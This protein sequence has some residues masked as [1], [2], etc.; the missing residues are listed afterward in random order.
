MDRR[1]TGETLGR[2]DSSMHT[3]WFRSPARIQKPLRR[4]RGR[5]GPH[6]GGIGRSMQ[7]AKPESP[8]LS[9]IGYHP[10]E[11]A[12]ALRQDVAMGQGTRST[13]ISLIGKWNGDGGVSRYGAN[14]PRV[15]ERESARR[16][17]KASARPAVVAPPDASASSKEDVESAGDRP[18]NPGKSG[19]VTHLG[20]AA[21]KSA[22]PAK[23]TGD[24]RRT[25]RVGAISR[26]QT[27]GVNGNGKG[28]SDEKFTEKEK[29]VVLERTFD[30][31]R[32]TIRIT[33]S[34]EGGIAAVQM[35]EGHE[36]HESRSSTGMRKETLGEFG[37]VTE[38]KG[39][40]TGSAPSQRGRLVQPPVSVGQGLKGSIVLSE[41][42]HA[43]APESVTKTNG[44]H[45]GGTVK[46]QHDNSL[47]DRKTEEKGKVISGEK[48]ANSVL[49][50][51][52][53]KIRLDH[54]QSQSL[55]RPNS[56]KRLKHAGPTSPQR[57]N[58]TQMLSVSQTPGQ[59]SLPMRSGQTAK[60]PS[61]SRV[62]DTCVSEKEAL[63]KE[64]SRKARTSETLST[65]K[66]P[67]HSNAVVQTS[68]F[69]PVAETP[70]VSTVVGK[71][72]SKALPTVPETVKSEPTLPSPSLEQYRGA[73]SKNDLETTNQRDQTKSD[74]SGKP[75]HVTLKVSVEMEENGSVLSGSSTKEG[76]TT[77]APQSVSLLPSFAAM[78][79]KSA[80]PVLPVVE[81][82]A[83]L[84]S[85]GLHTNST[86][87]K[88]FPDSKLSPQDLQS[89]LSTPILES[90]KSSEEPTTP[91][92]SKLDTHASIALSQKAA[93]SATPITN[94]PVS[95]P[96]PAISFLRSSPRAK[97][98]SSNGDNIFKPPGPLFGSLP[99]FNRPDSKSNN[100]ELNSTE[101]KAN[102]LVGQ[103]HAIE[104][105]IR[106]VERKLAVEN[107]SKS[108][109]Q[110]RAAKKEAD[111]RGPGNTADVK[112]LSMSA[113]TQAIA[114]KGEE[115]G[116]GG[117]Q[118]SDDPMHASLRLVL[119][120]NQAI[121]A[122]SSA[123][124]RA[125]C[126][127]VEIGLDDLTIT[128][129][130]AD[131][132]SDDVQKKVTSEIARRKADAVAR[133]KDLSRE[134]NALRGSW[135]RRV[136]SAWDKK[137]KEKRE[138]IRERD[139]FLVMCT[140]GQS[141]LLS[142]RTSSG[143]MS[144]K[145]I[146]SLTSNG[147]VSGNAEI[148]ALLSEIAAAGG[149]PG[150][151][152]KW[153]KTLATIPI[154]NPYAPPCDSTSVFVEDPLVDFQSSRAVNPWSFE[155]RL[156]FLD[157]F[158]VYPKD[159]RKIASFLEH[160]STQDCSYFYYLNKLDLGLKQ[161]A[162]E[163][164]TLKRKGVL[165]S[166]IVS[167]AKK[168]IHCES[169][170][171]ISFYASKYLSSS[172]T[173][174]SPLGQGKILHL[175]PIQLIDTQKGD[176]LAQD[177][178]KLPPLYMAVKKRIISECVSL[179]LSDIDEEAF[180]QAVAQ[181]GVDLREISKAVGMP[182]KTS[183]YYREMY[184]RH[185]RRIHSDDQENNGSV[186]HGVAGGNL[187]PS[188]RQSPRLS[189]KSSLDLLS[190]PLEC[191]TNPPLD[192]EPIML[193]E[194]TEV[195]HGSKD[196]GKTGTSSALSPMI[197]LKVVS[198]TAMDLE[199]R[200]GTGKVMSGSRSIMKT[201][202]WTPEE[203]EKFRQLFKKYK[204]D[205]KKIAQHLAPKTPEQV[206]GYWCKVAH[207]VGTG[208]GDNGKISK[209]EKKKT[210]RL[211]SSA[212]GSDGK[213]R[214]ERKRSPE[215]KLA[216][217]H[218]CR[219]G[220]GNSLVENE[221]VDCN[222]KESIEGERKGEPPEAEAEGGEKRLSSGRVDEME[223]KETKD[224]VKSG[225]MGVKEGFTAKSKE[226]QA[227]CVRKPSVLR[228]APT[229]ALRSV[230]MKDPAVMGKGFGVASS[231]EFSAARDDLCKQ[232]KLRR[233]AESYG[234]LELIDEKVR[235][236]DTEKTKR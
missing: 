61:N 197:K 165:K 75:K 204:R 213:L 26:G 155:E 79:A 18:K 113:L 55:L 76:E 2:G 187:T 40:S 219:E 112:T 163:A 141:A 127:N 169:V 164:A 214:E 231:D 27:S 39:I 72:E 11:R 211:H 135:R 43:P 119:S 124:F 82:R 19:A 126:H 174:S 83:A 227:Y 29:D 92:S 63:S 51:T 32:N 200:S 4:K 105:R 5:Y 9:R 47:N 3:P 87:S 225:P 190:S 170:D 196:S 114:E 25:V 185:K 230:A 80:A 66:V 120:R 34:M 90:T 41:H 194:G 94:I 58:R 183:S 180:E 64:T 179:D 128:S 153:S 156:I 16:G 198:D 86:V 85:R 17:E 7:L 157:K 68:A 24:D 167:L 136:K 143:R 88:N 149:T 123:V 146:P 172:H 37:S 188:L 115:S 117:R 77:K 99:S 182:N 44:V 74:E 161:L 6:M 95:V 203:C 125:L 147:H 60:I 229:P 10:G 201:A 129:V 212:T 59:T 57:T 189:P 102:E 118:L 109:S 67:T 20:G 96:A 215:K 73:M 235:G 122:G 171:S 186:K 81:L 45:H 65:E 71:V 48:S 144:M 192:P 50:A 221:G 70:V 175:E 111:G 116:H 220:E 148:D 28:V 1:G 166:H 150:L 205:W 223:I 224:E 160:K 23:P 108:L 22:T 193:D 36:S 210:K 38:G 30:P 15:F 138:A 110:Q 199:A 168:R 100:A 208:L 191:R 216:L 140:K 131:L 97:T 31:P 226:E 139:R 53:A 154:Q 121:A 184:R 13:G 107:A 54:P 62:I 145:V 176:A 104:E 137:S 69:K 142:S 93:L 228:S 177:K 91:S 218:N 84:S 132:P 195:T 162:K 209:C 159:F 101:Q 134:Y 173:S 21:E 35:R 133:T 152:E 56:P 106:A 14:S 206:K 233:T 46:N 33:K 222:N 207:E 8:I 52:A 42:R 178:W 49:G 130:R 98:R 236:Y 103:I 181:Y 78:N 158:A 217:D 12:G 232:D 151:K 89:S 234:V 202:T